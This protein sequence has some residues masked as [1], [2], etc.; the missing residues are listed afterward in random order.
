MGRVAHYA[1]W[2]GLFRKIKEDQVPFLTGRYEFMKLDKTGQETPSRYQAG[3][4]Y[5]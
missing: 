4:D 1:G 2:V 5:G 3:Y